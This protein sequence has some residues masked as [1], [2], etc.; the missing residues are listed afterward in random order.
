MTDVNIRTRDLDELRGIVATIPRTGSGVREPFGQH[1]QIE[2]LARGQHHKIEQLEPEPPVEKTITDLGRLSAEA[3]MQT[4]ET[5][6]S[7]VDAL[8]VDVKAMIGRL[9]DEMVRCDENLKRLA[10]TAADIMEQGK[11]T[12]A[13]IERSS[14]LSD[15]V[16]ATAEGLSKKLK[17]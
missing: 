5:T 6:A 7:R 15:D 8:G 1:H 13:L 10:E 12:M 11:L 9:R 16:R 17:G 14:Q 2:E 4:W 3:I